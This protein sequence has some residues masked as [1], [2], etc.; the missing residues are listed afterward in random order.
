M[1]HSHDLYKDHIIEVQETSHIQHS[2]MMFIQIILLLRWYNY[3]KGSVFQSYS[4]F[5]WS[6]IFDIIEGVRIEMIELVN[7]N[8]IQEIK[9]SLDLA[10]K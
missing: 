2:V 5:L 6:Q 10:W 8:E 7:R 9:M 4:E 1:D 3:S